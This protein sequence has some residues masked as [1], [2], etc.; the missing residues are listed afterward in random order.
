MALLASSRRELRVP[1]E[2]QTVQFGTSGHQAHVSGKVV[3]PLELEWT[4]FLAGK[5]YGGRAQQLLQHL[6]VCTQC[7][8]TFDQLPS[9]TYYS[10]GRPLVPTFVLSPIEVA[11]Q[12]DALVSE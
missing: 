6:E 7:A 2:V 9:P 12:V 10:L 4:F 8:A 11:A 3:H 5:V 1:A